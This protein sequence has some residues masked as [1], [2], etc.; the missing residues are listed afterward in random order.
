MYSFQWRLCRKTPLVDSAFC[1]SLK[2]LCFALLKKT[3]TVLRNTSALVNLAKKKVCP[4]IDL[5][6]FQ[7]DLLMPQL[8][9][10]LLS[11]L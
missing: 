5:Y 9:A 2:G 1:V 6:R 8:R 7:T 11:S 3:N 4:E 10:L